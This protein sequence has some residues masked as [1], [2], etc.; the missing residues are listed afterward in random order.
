[1]N[2]NTIIKLAAFVVGAVALLTLVSVSPVKTGL[3]AAAV[4][5]Y[6]LVDKVFPVKE[7]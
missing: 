6:L 5:V 3:A 4:A 1:M 2:K 7:V